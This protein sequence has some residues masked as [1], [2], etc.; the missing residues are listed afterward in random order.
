MDIPNSVELKNQVE[1]CEIFLFAYKQPLRAVME[2]IRNLLRKSHGQQ[3]MNMQSYGNWITTPVAIELQELPIQFIFYFAP[4][5]IYN[6]HGL[7][8][9]RWS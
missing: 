5:L 9:P 7:L 1:F 8:Y 6:S 4:H 3:V 2:N